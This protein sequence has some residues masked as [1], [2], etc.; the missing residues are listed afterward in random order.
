MVFQIRIS[1]SVLL[2]AVQSNG[3][4]EKAIQSK[5]KTRIQPTLGRI[6]LKMRAYVDLG[7]PI[8]PLLR[9]RPHH[10][11]GEG[12]WRARWLRLERVCGVC[13]GRGCLRRVRC[14]SL[15]VCKCVF[16]KLKSVLPQQILAVASSDTVSDTATSDSTQHQQQY[17]CSIYRVQEVL[18]RVRELLM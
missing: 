2:R 10:A 16:T 11:L 7:E 9:E 18:S 17:L 8:N 13:V 14:I 3:R 6:T 4:K 12:V 5:N 15:F 1:P